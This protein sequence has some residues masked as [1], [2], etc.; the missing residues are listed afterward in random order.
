MIYIAGDPFDDVDLDRALLSRAEACMLLTNKNSKNS[1]EE[2]YKNILTA[3]AIKKFVYN[4]NKHLKDEQKFNIKL[5]IQLIKPESKLLYYQSLN[6]SPVHD[7]LIIVEEIKM[8]LL[9]K[10]CFAPGLIALLSNLSAS[11]STGGLDIEAFG[12]EWLTEYAN[13]M[14]HEIYRVLI[15]ENEFYS[16]TPLSF[17]RIAE[18]CFH[19]YSAVVFALEIE[20]KGKNKSIVRLNPSNFTFHEWDRYS[21]YLY[22]IGED[23]SLA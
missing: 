11:A 14:G 6:L 7:Q 15:N 3:L 22:V 17:K 23:E 5:C 2:D 10:S 12:K 8:N 9:A 19:E 1:L 20:I 4:S 18:I 21:Y 16:P 13:G